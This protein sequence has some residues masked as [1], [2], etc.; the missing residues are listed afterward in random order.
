MSV[1]FKEV[2]PNE[3]VE[4]Y[5]MQPLR[6]GKGSQLK[7]AITFVRQL[8]KERQR[9]TPP[10]E[11]QAKIQELKNEM[12]QRGWAK[13]YK[14]GGLEKLGKAMEKFAQEIEK[15]LNTPTKARRLW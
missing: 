10:T 4:H 3:W 14:N 7:K 11:R 13:F 12:R 5:V 9:I 6:Q 2:L 8:R 1:E 15:T